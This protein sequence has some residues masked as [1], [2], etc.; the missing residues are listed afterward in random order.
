MPQALS[1]VHPTADSPWGTYL[2]QV[3]RVVPYLGHL[4]RWVETLKR[5]KRMLIVDV[6]IELDDGRVAHFE[7]F[8]VQHNLSRGPGKGGVRYH[9][10]VT[11]EEVMALAAWMSIK[12][13][14]VNLPFG[15][16]KGG[17]RVDPSQLSHKE[18]ERMTRRYTSEI[19][20]IIGPHSDIPAPDVNT[21]PQIMA[22]MMDTYSMNTG[23]TA[24]GVVTGKPIHLG[25]SL[26]RVKAT[27]RGVF[28]TGREAARR[29]DLA[30]DGA[31][32]AVQGFGNVG[33]AAAELFAQAGGKIVAAQDHTGTIFNDHGFD[34]ADLMAHVKATGGVGGFKGGEVMNAEEFWDVRCD[35]LIPAALEGQI[36]AN[37]A[38]R[39]KARLVLE[40][41]NGPTVPSADDI[42]AERGIL[43]VPDVICNAGGV[44]VSYFEWVQDFSSFFWTEDEINLRLDKIMIGALKRIWDTADRHQITLRTAT[45][46]VACER[47]L[48]ARQER[49]LYP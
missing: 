13:A 27:G 47:I 37:R 31:R 34:M 36:T 41:A 5:P 48:T 28:V 10:D 46:A 12:N 8:R 3:D 14:A 23:T 29:I 33:S 39:V 32:V 25:G 9:P 22:W 11:L 4:A 40:G 42:M 49:G 45:F 15:G 16:A 18:L 35:I 24:T 6:P 19:G 17:I 26:G 43:V 20:I 44:T 7:G 21:N 38:R 2:M 1:Y 30:L